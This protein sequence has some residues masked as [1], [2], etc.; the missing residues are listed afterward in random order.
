MDFSL[1][2]VLNRAPKPAKTDVNKT[3]DSV[4]KGAKRDTSGTSVTLHV[5]I[6]V[7]HQ[8]V[9]KQMDSVLR[10]AKKDTTVET[11]RRTVLRT[12][13]KVVVSKMERVLL[14][15]WMVSTERRVIS[16]VP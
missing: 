6:I 10:D 11:V 5:R 13:L 1:Q 8:I 14:D 7:K 2:P 16:N 4:P 3:K 9:T 15:A 12:V